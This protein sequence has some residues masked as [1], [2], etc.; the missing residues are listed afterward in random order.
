MESEFLF[1]THPSS[2]GKIKERMEEVEL[3]LLLEKTRKI[4][5]KFVDDR[6]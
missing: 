2:L 4:L 3:E 1:A 5:N 6:R